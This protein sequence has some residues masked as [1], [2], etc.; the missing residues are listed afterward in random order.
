MSLLL[1]FDPPSS[2][3]VPAP[4]VEGE[5]SPPAVFPMTHNNLAAL[6]DMF[7]HEAAS[8]ENVLTHTYS[9]S[10]GSAA[11]RVPSLPTSVRH[12]LPLGLP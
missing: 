4:E 8:P 2:L 11:V 9:G 5:E 3:M 12:S 10:G 6:A 7:E 1:H